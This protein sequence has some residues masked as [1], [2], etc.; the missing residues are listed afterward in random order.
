MNFIEDEGV[1][2]IDCAIPFRLRPIIPSYTLFHLSSEL[3][4]RGFDLKA[5][6]KWRPLLE[7][8]QFRKPARLSFSEVQVLIQMAVDETSDPNLGLAVG[9]R[10]SIGSLGPLS[11]ALLTSPTLRSALAVGIRYHRLSGSLIELNQSFV[12]NG[13]IYLSINERYFGA[14]ISG[15]VMQEFFGCFSRASRYLCR[16]NSPFRNV[17][18]IFEMADRTPLEEAFACPVETGARSN[19]IVMSSEA[20]DYPL[21][22]ADAYAH[23]EVIDL[24]DSLIRATEAQ[25]DFLEQTERALVKSIKTPPSVNALARQLGTSER[26]LRRRL[27][28]VGTSYS[29]LIEKLRVDHAIQLLHNGKLSVKQISSQ[30]GFTDPRSLRRLMMARVGMS[31]TKL[32]RRVDI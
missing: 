21:E 13:E 18:T 17:S 6:P 4:A 27:S 10:Q 14:T 19:E 9:L 5:D 26:T 31:A 3:A 7:L 1:H 20:L 22:T 25:Q 23:S 2:R 12:G 16:G 15:F 29:E 24:L 28:E 32:R 11:S 30:V 8:H